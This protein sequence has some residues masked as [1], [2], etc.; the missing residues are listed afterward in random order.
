MQIPRRAALTALPLAAMAA[1]WAGGSA[2][3]ASEPG[4][5]PSGHRAGGYYV[6][7]TG[8]GLPMTLDVTPSGR[9]VAAVDWEFNCAGQNA[10]TALQSIRI[11]RRRGLPHR[12]AKRADDVAIRF[13][14][15]GLNEFGTVTTAGRFRKRGRRVIGTFSVVSPTCGDT[16]PIG[17][18]GKLDLGY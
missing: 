2:P 16:G 18:S 8:P 7:T 4:A 9:R 12:F 5:S 13:T 15:S 10:Q 1:L 11:R 3:A 17:Y 6:G 14:E